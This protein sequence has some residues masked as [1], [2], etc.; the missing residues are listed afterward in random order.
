MGGGPVKVLQIGFRQE[1][2]TGAGLSNRDF[3]R[4]GG[5]CGGLAERYISGADGTGLGLADKNF[6]RDGRVGGGIAGLD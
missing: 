5:S 1:W 2:R 3:G 6:G 4:V